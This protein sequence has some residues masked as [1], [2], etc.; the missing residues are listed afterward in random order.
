MPGR[1]PRPSKQGAGLSVTVTEDGS[2]PIR[3][4][5]VGELDL[6]TAG[7]V[8]VALAKL[9]GRQGSDVHLDLT[10]L[11]FCDAR[12]LRALV[13]SRWAVQE[14]GGHLVLTGVPKLTRR[15][16]TITGLDEFFECSEI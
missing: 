11:T 9:D 10:E 4:R 13:E 8:P 7:Q 12:G 16:L 2:G 3:V 15:L 1:S 14:S 5:L 6:A